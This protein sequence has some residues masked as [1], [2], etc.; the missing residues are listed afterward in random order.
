M[1][2]ENNHTLHSVQRR[3]TTTEKAALDTV[4]GLLELPTLPTEMR[5]LDEHSNTI[6]RDSRVIV[7]V[8]FRLTEEGKTYSMCEANG[9]SCRDERI[10]FFP[11]IILLK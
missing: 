5:R 1:Y 4:Q 10:Y 6:G 7:S 3:R 9:T 8:Y 2:H 11:S